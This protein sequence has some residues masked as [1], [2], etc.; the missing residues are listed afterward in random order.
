MDL[1][2]DIASENGNWSQI[3]PLHFASDRMIEDFSSDA[4]STL[5]RSCIKQFGFNPNETHPLR[6]SLE[7][8]DWSVVGSLTWKNGSRRRDCEQAEKCRRIDF[9]DLL[10]KTCIKLKLRRKN[11]FYYHA[12]EYGKAGECHFHFLLWNTKSEQIPNALLA[13]TMQ[14]LWLNNFVPFDHWHTKGGAGTAE[15]TAY[16]EGKGNAAVN[17]CLKREY[18]QHGNERERYD[19][20]SDN[21]FR[22]LRKK[23]NYYQG[24]TTHNSPS[25]QPRFYQQ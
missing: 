25:F 3:C 20:L 13:D 18:D 19:N 1:I 21:L 11:V 5:E 12:T 10:K 4:K 24:W 15:I 8:I 23:V 6:Y 7:K 22:I 9:N 2:N 17:Y 16:D 14:S